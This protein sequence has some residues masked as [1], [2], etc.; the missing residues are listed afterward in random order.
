MADPFARR[1]H[2]LVRQLQPLGIAGLFVSNP[3]SVAYLTGFTG[4]ASYLLLNAQRSL[5][6]SD[7]R[8]DEQIAEEAP[9]L[10]VHFRP[11]TRTTLPEVADVLAKLGWS[12]VGFEAAHLTVAALETLREGAKASDFRP[13]TGLVETLRAVKDADEVRQIREAVAVAERAFAMLR[14]S[15]NGETTERDLCDALEAFVRRAGGSASS[16]EPIAAVGPRS[17]LAHAPPTART[18]ASADFLLVDWGARKGRYVSDLTRMLV[19]RKSWF[20]TTR[21][22]SDDPQLAKVYRAVLAAHRRAVATLRPG[23]KACDVDAAARGAL[24]EAG[25]GDHFTHG[26]GHGIGLEIHEA[27]DLRA[28]SEQVLAAGMVVTVEPG[29]YF[30]GWGGVRIEDDYLVT[31]A[32]CERLSTLPLDLP[33]ADIL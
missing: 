24:G 5:L 31:A 7:H 8:F 19:T 23:V 22:R 29:A 18:V 15:L 12:A 13:T 33:A 3:V 28:S 4:G 14:A 20:R 30:P 25:F 1:R 10:D 17:A 6:V 11:P 32:G 26:L 2:R 16:F 27:P 21:P 9:G